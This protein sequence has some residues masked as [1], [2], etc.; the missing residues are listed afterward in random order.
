VTCS[1]QD[2]FE[3]LRALEDVAGPVVATGKD[4]YGHLD[5]LS[6]LFFRQKGGAG[7][8]VSMSGGRGGEDDSSMSAR[9]V[10]ALKQLDL[11]RH[12]AS[13]KLAVLHSQQ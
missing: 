8:E 10:E 7:E 1:S 3:I 13:R 9:T 6:R 11:V 2:V 4:V 12:A 5:A